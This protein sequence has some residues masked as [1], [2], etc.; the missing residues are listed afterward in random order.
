MKIAILTIVILFSCSSFAVGVSDSITT[1]EPKESKWKHDEEV[2]EKDKYR[3]EKKTKD[4][5]EKTYNT[6][7]D[8]VTGKLKN[9]LDSSGIKGTDPTY[10]GLPKRKWRVSLIGDMDDMFV[11]VENTSSEGDKTWSFDLEVRPPM[12]ASSGIWV[13]YMGY[14][15]GFSYFKTGQNSTNLAMNFAAPS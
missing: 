15:F 7:K 5:A 3:L 12:S 8:F 11:D 9:Y 14:G 4:L 6:T 1:S 2:L 10:I 13:G